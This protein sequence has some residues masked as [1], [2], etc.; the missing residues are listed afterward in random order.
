[1]FLW[2]NS[3]ILTDNLNKVRRKLKNVI[4]SDIIMND[5]EFKT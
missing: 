3:Y 4:N 5:I 2:H 1:M